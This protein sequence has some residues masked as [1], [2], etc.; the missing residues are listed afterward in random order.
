MEIMYVKDIAERAGVTRRTVHTWMERHGLG[1][2]MM[3]L[4]G[5]LA[6]QEK[7]WLH[8]LESRSLTKLNEIGIHPVR[9]NKKAKSE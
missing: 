7:E 2:Y 5:R 3:L 9:R 8:Y 1:E 6:I 4:G